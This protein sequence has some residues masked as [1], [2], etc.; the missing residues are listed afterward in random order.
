MLLSIRP[1]IVLPVVM[2]ITLVAW[3]IYRCLQSPFHYPYFTCH[4]D[5]SGKRTPDIFNE[6]DT[7]INQGGFFEIQRH[8]KSIAEWK[9]TCRE[10]IETTPFR[11][12]RQRQYDRC[13]DDEQAFRFV[14]TRDQ[15][16][17]RQV[18]YEKMSYTTKMQT[19]EWAFS[20][21]WLKQ[22]YEQL[23]SIG[24]ESTLSR[25]GSQSQRKMMTRELRRQIME[26]DHYTCQICGKYMPDEVGLQID[27]IIP[28]SRGG[29]TVPSNLQVLCSKC[30]GRKHDK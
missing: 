17:Y 2:A 20:Y 9:E 8:E 6:I 24:F 5:V 14:L 22:R 26:R 3:L 18:H 28:V 10:K 12:L 4:L 1:E 27:H 21:E 30:N 13:L 23:S 15:T 7:Y 29:K 16:R 19:Q 11:G 25:Y